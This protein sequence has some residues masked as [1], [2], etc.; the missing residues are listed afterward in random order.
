M[1]VHLCR[2]EWWPMYDEVEEKYSDI[3]VEMDDDEYA[4]FFSSLAIVRYYQKKFDDAYE[5]KKEK[6]NA[7]SGE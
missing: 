5:K 6:E 2:D 3:T 1:K 4:V 7:D